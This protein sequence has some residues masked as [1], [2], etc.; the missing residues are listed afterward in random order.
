MS[1]AL[2]VNDKDNVATVFAENVGE[3]AGV[4]LVDKTGGRRQIVA[5]CPVPYGHKIALFPIKKG[6]TVYKYGESIGFA[7][8]DIAAGGHVHIHNMESARGRGDL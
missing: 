1:L 2:L 4:L 8:A 7:S 5:A 6:E 3:G